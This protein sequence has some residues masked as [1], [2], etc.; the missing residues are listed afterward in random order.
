[1]YPQPHA[2]TVAADA[3]VHRGTIRFDFTAE[4]SS[5]DESHFDLSLPDIK[6]WTNEPQANKCH[7]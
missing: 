7:Q 1:M 6:L 3:R 2:E 5:A 4:G